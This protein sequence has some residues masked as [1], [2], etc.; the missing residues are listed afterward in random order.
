M[1]DLIREKAVSIRSPLAPE[2]IHLTLLTQAEENVIDH[3]LERRMD[4]AQRISSL[5][6]SLRKKEM[7]RVRQPLQKI[8][9]P[10]LDDRFQKDVDL[11]KELILAEV[12]VKEIEY[13]REDSGIIKKKAKPNYKTLGKRLGKHMKAAAQLIDELSQQDINAIERDKG[14]SLSINGESFFLSLDDLEIVT[15]DIPGWTVA[16]D[17]SITVA[18]DMTLTDDLLAEGMARELVNRIQNLRKDHGFEVTDRIAVR[19]EAHDSISNAIQRYGTY[20]QDEVLADKLEVDATVRQGDPVELPD[21]AQLHI[22]V[23][24]TS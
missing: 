3:A 15:E 19:L 24:R 8:L 17:G 5:V 12:N 14:Y 21:G 4:Y 23:E 9:L 18:L 20:I 11:V 13:V 7:I 6:L 2:S 10:V 1:T 16:S 22:H